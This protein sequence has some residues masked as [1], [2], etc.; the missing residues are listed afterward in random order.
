[1]TEDG[2]TAPTPRRR[3]L[4]RPQQRARHLL[5]HRRQRAARH[6]PRALRRGAGR[7]RPRRP[8]GAG[9]RRRRSGSRSP[10]ASC[11]RSTPPARR[12][13]SPATRPAAAW[14]CT[15]PAQVPRGRSARSTSSSRCCTARTART[16]RSRGCSRWP[17]SPTS[18][19][20]CSPRPPRMDKG[21][22]KVAAARRRAPGRA[23]RR[24]HRRATGATDQAAVLRR[25]RGG[26]RLPGLRQAGP[27]RLQRRHQQGRTTRPSSTTPSRQARAHDPQGARRGRRSTGREI[28]CGV[29]EGLDGGPPEA[30]VPGEI[31]VGGRPRVLRLRGEVPPDDATELDVPA[32]LPDAVGRPRSS[33]L[34]L[35]SRSRRSAARAW[36]GSTSS[37]PTTAGWSS[38]RSTRCPGFT[39]VSMF[40][41]M[42]AAS[43]VD[44]PALVDRLVRRRWRG[45][46]GLR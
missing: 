39:P 29:L 38:T 13:C 4:R 9:R 15:S 43:G 8:L 19:P 14:S 31:R 5:R 21:H 35:R 6:R 23:V 24:G 22:M 7:H 27:R 46:P 3:R 18:A 28:E 25:D 16:A 11:P 33:A 30:S 32:D 26:A 36:P 20:G 1:M 45:R 37:S 12:S 42:W 40:P 34:A 2:P 17:A 44:Y 10:A 41:R